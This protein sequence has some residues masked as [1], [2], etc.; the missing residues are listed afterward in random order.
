MK[1][2][3]Q[4]L[5]IGAVASVAVQG[6]SAPPQRELALSVTAGN[7]SGVLLAQARVTAAA[8]LAQAGFAFAGPVATAFPLP[9]A[10]APQSTSARSIF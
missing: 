8:I 4:I 3:T 9:P 5:C 6:G 1:K 2:L 7:V 10:P